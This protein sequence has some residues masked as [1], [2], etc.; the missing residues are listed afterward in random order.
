[1]KKID[2]L[3]K[4]NWTA[5]RDESGRFKRRVTSMLLRNV[6]GQIWGMKGYSAIT[7][8]VKLGSG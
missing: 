2:G 7:V 4:E 6:G 8:R 5:K 1:M 3:K